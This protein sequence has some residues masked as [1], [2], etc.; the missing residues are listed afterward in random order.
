MCSEPKSIVN[1]LADDRHFTL[2]FV[3]QSSASAVREAQA[4]LAR[5][6]ESDRLVGTQT[7]ET[8]NLTI[9]RPRNLVRFG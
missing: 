7:A 5:R 6:T 4:F 1:T 9:E 3:S 2:E 8:V